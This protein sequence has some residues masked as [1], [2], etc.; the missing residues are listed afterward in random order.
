MREFIRFTLMRIACAVLSYAA[1]LLALVWVR[2]EAAYV[3][4]Y[5]F[6][7]A[8]AYY[9]TAR[10]VFDEPLRRK[11]A[12]LFPLVYFLQFVLGYVLIRFAVETLGIPEWL[13]LAFSVAITLPLTFVLS[14]WIVRLG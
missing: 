6:G 7:V 9:T 2:Y 12:L 13:G 5:I 10:L 3:L 11:S 8:L 14:R 1:Y 4:S